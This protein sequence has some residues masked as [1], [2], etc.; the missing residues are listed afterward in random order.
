[1]LSRRLSARATSLAVTGIEETH[2]D[3]RCLAT[4]L[5]KRRLELDRLRWRLKSALPWT[6]RVTKVLQETP[7]MF[8]GGKRLIFPDWTRF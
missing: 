8:Q 4:P 6:T 2:C 7:A 1:M 5:K 3:A